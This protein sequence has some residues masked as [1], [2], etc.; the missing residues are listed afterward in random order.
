VGDVENAQP[1]LADLQAEVDVGEVDGE[2][3]AQAADL[4]VELASDGQAGC[5]HRRALAVDQQW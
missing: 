4:V 5:G 3:L 2:G 1:A